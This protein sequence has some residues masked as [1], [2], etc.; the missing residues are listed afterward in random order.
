MLTSWTEP[1]KHSASP[2]SVDSITEQWVGADHCYSCLDQERCAGGAGGWKDAT[3]LAWQ[4]SLFQPCRCAVRRTAKTSGLLFISTR[5]HHAGVPEVF[6]RH[7][8]K[9]RA[10][11]MAIGGDQTA[12]LLWRLRNGEAPQKNKVRGGGWWWLLLLLLHC[13]CTAT[14]KRASWSRGEAEQIECRN[15]TTGCAL[16]SSVDLPIAPTAN[17]VATL[18]PAAQGGGP[19]HRHQ[20]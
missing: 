14:G 7:F 20:W 16:R 17:N 8:G 19:A 1:A 6:T 3:G 9:W 10:G 5:P 11:A 4:G 12:H 2:V 13:G 18:L 15:A